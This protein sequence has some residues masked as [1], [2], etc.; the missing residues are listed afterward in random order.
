MAELQGNS[1][2]GGRI[3]ATN[4]GTAGRNR[5]G[6]R[7]DGRTARLP[8][9]LGSQLLWGRSGLGARKKVQPRKNSSSVLTKAEPILGASGDHSSGDSRK[10]PAVVTGQ[11]H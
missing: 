4:G 10:G 1:E 3:G 5:N 11:K 6:Q 2:E 7:N 9:L 8:R